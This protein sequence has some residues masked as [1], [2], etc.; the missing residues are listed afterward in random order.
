[1]QLNDSD[2][3]ARLREIPNEQEDSFQEV[4]RAQDEALAP[5]AAVDE[6]CRMVF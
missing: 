1:M 2:V 4:P 5:P 6:G 3:T